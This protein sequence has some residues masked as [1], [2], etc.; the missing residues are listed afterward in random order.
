MKETFVDADGT[1]L[2]VVTQGT[3][4]TV[5]MLHGWPEF[6]W[7]WRNQ[8]PALADAGYRAVAIDLP[9][10]GDSDK[11]ERDYTE[12]WVNT[13]IAALIRQIVPTGER[14]VIVGHD[15]GGL[16]IWPFARRYPEL[17]AGVV[18]LNTPDLARGT[19]PPLA[20][21]EKVFTGHPNY[22]MQFQDFGPAD[23]ILGRDV[24]AWLE[25]MYLGPVTVQRDAFTPEVLDRYIEVFS[26]PGAITPPLSYYRNMDVNWHALAT[27]DERID[28][29]ALMISTTG[30]PV[31]TPAMVE[32]MEERVPDLERIVF[33]ECGHWT[34]QERPAETNAAIIGFCDRVF[35]T[36]GGAGQPARS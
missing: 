14:C 34:Q 7:S 8:L 16:L 21:M 24:R 1:R 9:G 11:P 22:I 35:A 13:V 30:D 27:L 15:W 20:V 4:P 31:L 26:R 36:T 12:A 17:L 19:L 2:H 6:W 18:G 28:L 25:A 29:P 5:V 23:W 33:D 32:G 10:Y 3:G